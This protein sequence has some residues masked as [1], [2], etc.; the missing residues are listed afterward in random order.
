MGDAAREGII[1]A[2]LSFVGE[3]DSPSSLGA[4]VEDW[5]AMGGCDFQEG[6]KLLQAGVPPSQRPKVWLKMAHLHLQAQL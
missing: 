4:A 6:C 3:L 1:D 5:L 2:Y